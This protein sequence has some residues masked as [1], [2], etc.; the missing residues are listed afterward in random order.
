MCL[1]HIALENKLIGWSARPRGGRRVYIPTVGEA[2]MLFVLQ[3][4][5]IYLEASHFVRRR[6]TSRSHFHQAVQSNY[7]NL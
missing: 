5:L 2:M 4:V 7:A 6:A 1:I 3:S